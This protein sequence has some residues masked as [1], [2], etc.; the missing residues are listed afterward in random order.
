LAGGTDINRAAAY[1]EERIERPT[2]AHLILITD[3]YE[4]GNAEALVDRLARLVL[5]GVN[6]IVLLALTDTG[7]PAYNPALSAKVA[8]L[9][10]PVFACTPD[11]F[12]GPDGDRAEAR[13]RRRLGRGPGHQ[14]DPS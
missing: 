2:K 7:R 3:L 6:V 11:Q 10:I 8:A 4:G 9:G 14:A 5:R 12:S 13:G 1:C